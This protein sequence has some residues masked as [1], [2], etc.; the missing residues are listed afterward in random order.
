M[1]IGRYIKFVRKS[2]GLSQEDLMDVCSVKTLSRTENGQTNPSVELLE[3]LSK[4]LNV[5]FFSY[6]TKQLKEVSEINGETKQQ[7][8]DL[9][10]AMNFKELETLTE[11][12]RFNY[13]YKS[14]HD[15][16]F[17]NYYYCRASY[18]NNFDQERTLRLLAE[19]FNYQI[20]DEIDIVKVNSYYTLLEIRTILAMTFTYTSHYDY[21]RCYDFLVP[22]KIANIDPSK[23]ETDKLG[24]ILKLNYNKMLSASRLG[25]FDEVVDDMVLSIKIAEKYKLYSSISSSYWLYAKHLFEIDQVEECHK[26]CRKFLSITEL[27]G[28]DK[29]Y[30]KYSEEFEEK[31]GYQH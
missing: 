30:D 15:F 10:D 24:L 17:I 16:Q 7:I 1:D 20:D 26:Y 28:H 5:D 31:Y 8:I 2:R 9:N 14:I 18:I 6:K 27:H 11:P 3:K 21:Q 19:S 4:K 25:L 13:S 29:I 22:L 23:V 12:L